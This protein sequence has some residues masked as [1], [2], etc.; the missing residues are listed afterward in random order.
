MFFQHTVE[1]QK[2]FLQLSQKK[3]ILPPDLDQMK[4]NLKDLA[5]SLNATL[6]KAH[7][8]NLQTQ[9]KQSERENKREERVDNI[10]RERLAID[11]LYTE[12]FTTLQSNHKERMAQL[13]GLQN[14]PI[15]LPS[16]ND[17]PK[18]PSTSSPFPQPTGST[19][20]NDL[21]QFMLSSV[22]LGGSGSGLMG[23]RGSNGSLTATTATRPGTANSQPLPP[24]VVIGDFVNDDAMIEG[25]IAD[26]LSD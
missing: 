4:D 14:A 26:M 3:V 7:A 5:T 25:M 17:L 11:S 12:K 23:P 6:S 13:K 24:D 16:K 21:N 19:N 1:R 2:E 20:S 15:V 9:T 10:R 18:Q 8:I 22:V